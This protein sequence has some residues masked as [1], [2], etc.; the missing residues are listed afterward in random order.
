MSS[1]L[2]SGPPFSYSDQSYSN[3][4]NLKVGDIFD[5]ELNIPNKTIKY[6]VNGKD[7][8]VAYNGIPVDQPL[9]L[10]IL[11]AYTNESVELLSV[12]QL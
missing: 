11:S 7:C 4:G 10:T 6:Y 1:A 8:G 2:S 3:T 12:T 5:V 9:R